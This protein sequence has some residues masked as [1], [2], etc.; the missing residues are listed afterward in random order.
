MRAATD[1]LDALTWSS[2]IERS[3][4]ALPATELGREFRFSPRIG[5]REGLASTD[6]P[7]G[8]E[9]FVDRA[10][11]RTLIDDSRTEGPARCRSTA[12]VTLPGV[13]RSQHFRFRS[14]YLTDR[15]R[16]PVTLGAQER[17]AGDPGGRTADVALVQSSWTGTSDLVVPKVLD[18]GQVTDRDRRTVMD[19]TVEEALD[20]SLVTDEQIPA[21]T[22]EVLDALGRLWAARDV[23]HAPLDDES[24]TRAGRELSALGGHGVDLGLWPKRTDPPRLTHQAQALVESDVVLSRGPSHGDLGVGNLLRL[25]DGRLALVDWEHAG[26]RLL[27]H[28][29]LK[30]LVTSGT[31]VDRWADLHPP[32]PA[33]GWVRR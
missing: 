12:D 17:A 31:P 20:G 29:V 9:V 33:P 19:Y 2:V 22:G 8:R 27:S 15:V 5:Y 28:D 21:A 18:V 13:M 16:G 10:S 32:I 1:S 30:L 4:S 25:G 3:C 14:F 6:L 24:R 11:G 23:H 7:I 26:V